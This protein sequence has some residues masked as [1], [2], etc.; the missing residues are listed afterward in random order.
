[1][2][3][4]KN[5]KKN[6]E[7][8]IEEMRNFASAY[9]EKYAPS[10]QQL[11]TYLLKKYLKSSIP[12]VKK[13]DISELINLVIEDLEKTKFISDKFYSES[14]AKSL[15]Q[16]GSSIN[17]IKNYLISKGIKDHHIKETINKIKENNEDQDFFSAIKVCKKKRIGPAREEDNR[18]LFYKKD[19]SILA[20]S[21][22]DFETSKK[23]L[24]IEKDDYL[25]IVRLL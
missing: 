17:K 2:I 6:L 9:I 21:G 20:R 14:K 1:M 11:K 13:K 23:I 7:M 16:R 3:P 24:E 5:K 22:F 19:I 12:T 10:K 18:E 8:T 25:R 4:I 15:I